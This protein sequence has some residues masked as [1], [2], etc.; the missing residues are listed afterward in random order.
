MTFTRRSFLKAS[1]AGFGAAVLSL[2]ITGCTFDNDDDETIEVSFEHGVAS[3]D[4]LSDS[5]ILWTRVTP[6]DA[7][8]SSIKVQWQAATDAD[9]SNI[10][11]DGE[12]HVSD[13]TDFTLKVDLQGLDANTTYYYRFKSNGKTSPIG[14][15]KTLPTGSIDK[16][17]FAVI[18]CAN[19]PAGFFHVYGEIAKQ[20]DLDAV[21][22]LGDYIYEYG[23]GGYASEDAALL[24]RLLPEDNS[25]EIISLTDYRKRYAHYRTD[26]N[27]QAAHSN[28]AF[29]TVWDDH[30]VTNDTWREG[31]ENHNDGEGEFNARK[32][33]ALQAYFEWMPIRN[34]ADKERIYRRFEFG[35]LVSLYMLDTRVLARDEQLSYGDFDLT[36]AQGQSDFVAAIS[37]PTRAL[38]GNEQLTW[39]TDG[40]TNSSSKWQVLGQQVLMTKMHLPFEVLQLL[41]SLQVS[42]ANGA[43]TNALLAQA[44]ALFAELAQIKGRI[45]AGDPTVTDAERA[46]VDTTAPYNLD[47]WDGYAYE[48]EVLLG[49]AIATQ[50]NLVVLAGDTHNA[51]AGQLTT[52]AS[53]PIAASQ[54]AGVEFAT[55]SVSS[56]GLEEYLALNTQGPEAT[57]QMEQVIPLLVNDLVYNNLVDR[58]YLTVTFTPE[59]AEAKWNYVSSI[60][61]ASYEMQT[62]RSKALHMLA[63]QPVIQ[64]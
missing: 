7:A 3:G 8:A 30:E 16:V 4:P 58:G 49:T 62:E 45:L 5:L 34:V 48:R 63:G 24:G 31:A 53:N 19:Y 15:G 59:Q 27:L 6:L 1:A 41:V 44:S 57:A 42:Q 10:V 35:D 39:L 9:F 18:S 40:M 32:M 60:K 61:T 38:L 47:A 29:I 51:W 54:N 37:S 56:P 17:K 22:H 20:T 64:G 55:S 11:H 14:A 33:H 50:K 52:D 28:C 12:T 43:D 21:L 36:S 23:N 46:R 25:D 26:S 13:A 2:G